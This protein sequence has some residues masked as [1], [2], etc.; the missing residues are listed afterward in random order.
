[1]IHFTVEMEMMEFMGKLER[2]FSSGKTE[3]T[4]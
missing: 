3:M 1:M 2:M 4:L